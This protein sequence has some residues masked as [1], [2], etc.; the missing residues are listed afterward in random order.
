MRRL[1]IGAAFGFLLI[2]AVAPARA[3]SPHFKHGGIPTCRDT[4]TQLVCTGSLAGLGN[5][6]VDIVLEADG[7]A[8]FACRNKGGNEAPGQNKVHLSVGST[9]HFEGNEI[10]NGNLTFTAIAPETPPTATAQEAGCPNGNWTTRLLTLEFSNVVLTI[11]Q[12]DDLLFTC[13]HDGS[14]GSSPVRLDC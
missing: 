14:I 4:G 9:T 8:T 10:K 11:S 1:F 7:V 5:Q 13:T 12:G 6:D 3:D 2:L